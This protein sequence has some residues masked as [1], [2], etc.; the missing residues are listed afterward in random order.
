MFC[1][2]EVGVLELWALLGGWVPR[3]ALVLVLSRPAYYVD[4]GSDC[5]SVSRRKV[6]GEAWSHDP[7]GR[8]FRPRIRASGDLSGQTRRF[9]IR[10]HPTGQ[11]GRKSKARFEG[12]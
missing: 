7:G 2:A 9:S 11:V 5:H 4:Q 12:S 10:T 8:G 3:R 6:F 1:D